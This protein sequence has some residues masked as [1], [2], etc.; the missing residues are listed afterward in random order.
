MTHANTAARGLAAAAVVLLALSSCADDSKSSSATPPAGEQ[1]VL[2]D[3][4]QSLTGGGEATA[5]TTAGDN[6][7]A[8]PQVPAQ[9]YNPAGRKLV[10]TMTVGVEVTD[11]AAAVDKVIALADQ[12]GGQLYNSSLDLRDPATAAGDLV[13]KLPPEQVQAFLA[14][15][16][17]GIG[18]RTGL[19]GNTADVTKQLTDLGAQILTAEAS[20]DR[21][22]ALL[23]GATNLADVITLESELAIRETNLERLR[24]DQA[25]LDSQ[26][27][28]A[29]ITVRLTTAPEEAAAPTPE[30]KKDK[31]IGDAFRDG[32][33]GFVAVLAGVAIF[34][35]YTAPFLVIG[36]LAA[37][38]WWRV[39]RRRVAGPPRNRSVAPPPPPAP[40]AGPHMSTPDSADAARIP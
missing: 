13:F 40:G 29:T 4:D 35:G 8:T 37:L 5:D 1:Q 38:I 19:Q 2:P 31:G 39:R 11:A 26:V 15:L 20:V 28:Q 24:A 36:A 27:A 3:G 18:R 10:I 16:D 21:V 25:N 14:G 34:I 9:P 12:Y 22:R 33:K 32:W 23:E 6:S 7:S 17:P 30:P